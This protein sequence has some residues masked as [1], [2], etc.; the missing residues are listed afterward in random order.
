MHGRLGWALAALLATAAAAGPAGAHSVVDTGPPAGN[1]NPLPAGALARVTPRLISQQLFDHWYRIALK[2]NDGNPRAETMGFLIQS[3]W[4]QLE[5]A[6]HGLGVSRRTVRREFR[7]QKKEAFPTE[8]EYQRF[9]KS[10]GFTEQDVR[11]RVKL[12]LLQGRLLAHATARAKSPSG[13]RRARARFISAFQR[14]WKARTGCAAGYVVEG[15][16]HQLALAGM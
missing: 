4:I 13:R 10:S 5:A 12:D 14:K 1:E 15:C 11:Y 6:D 9:L 16:G 2:G 7:K 8:R 3:V